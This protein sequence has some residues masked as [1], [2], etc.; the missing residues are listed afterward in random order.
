MITAIFQSFG[1]LF[2]LQPMVAILPALILGLLYVK[3]KNKTTLITAI[4]WIFYGVYEE[5]HL[6]RILCSGECNIR[7]DLLLIYP[8]LIVLSIVAVALEVKNFIKSHKG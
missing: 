5:L 6:L 2:I 1:K 8:I 3:S 7:I 4:L